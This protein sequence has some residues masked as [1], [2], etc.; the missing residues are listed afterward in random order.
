MKSPLATNSQPTTQPANFKPRME[1]T[2]VERMRRISDAI[3]RRAYELFEAR[4]FEHGHDQEDWLRAESELLNPVPA[5]VVATNGG[6]TIRAE[7]PGFAHKDVEVHLELD[8]R[9][10]MPKAAR[11]LGTREPKSAPEAKHVG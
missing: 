8:G 1:G 11:R 6:L 7:V 10:S 4:G 9:S 5:K 3:A 2:Y